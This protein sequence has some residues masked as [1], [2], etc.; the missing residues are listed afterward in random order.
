MQKVLNFFSELLRRKVVRLLCA[1]IAVLWILAQGFASIYPI[2]DLSI[3]SLRIFI[4]VG[5][6]FIPV[7]AWLSWKYD[8]TAPH[9]VRDAH[10][11]ESA[12]PNLS[13]AMLRHDSKEAGY[14][15]LKW[16]DEDGKRQE[17]RFFKALSVGRDDKNEIQLK[18]ER[19]SRHH[20]VFWAE[21]G[22]WFIKDD[23]TNGTYL[24]HAR[25]EGHK[26]L[27]QSCDLQFHPDGPVVSIFIDKPAAT[28]VG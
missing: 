16:D 25:I 23:S 17:K 3:W 26:E 7:I 19:V 13:W 5:V 22:K 15:M 21:N 18:D 11:V 20:A 1:Y 27:P 14:I 4:I 10:D 8:I 9:L 28:M 24:N 6:A 12:N 2:F